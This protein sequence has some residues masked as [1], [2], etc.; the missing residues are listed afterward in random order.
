[1]SKIFSIPL[2]SLVDSND[3]YEIYL[4]FL[5]K[6]K[7]YIYDVY[8]T[9]R[10]PPFLQDAMGMNIM[11]ESFGSLFTNAMEIQNTI[12]IKVSATFNNINVSPSYNNLNIFIENLKPLYKNGLRSM[13]IPHTHW[14]A[15]GLKDNFPEMEIKNTILR[16]VSTAQ[17]YVQCAEQGF[18]YVNVDRILMRDH[19]E[20]KRIKKAQNHIKDKYDK[21][22]KIALLANEG[23]LGRCPIMDEHYSYNNMMTMNDNQY[24]ATEISSVSCTKWEKEDPA[25][26]YKTADIPLFKEDWDELLEYV[27]I[28][29]MHGREN[30]GKLMETMV[31]IKD[32]VKGKK[33]LGE[34]FVKDNSFSFYS[35]FIGIPQK[36]LDFWRDKIK[37]CK[38][39][40]WDCNY[41]NEISSYKDPN[42]KFQD[43]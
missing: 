8:F 23:C 27:D 12:G 21:I 1:M 37:V 39:Q 35:K 3:F 7:E 19:E 33:V 18:D 40:C 17:D 41:C 10:V 6:H 24:F 25:Y 15:M 4:P 34:K 13:T 20:L 30:P 36:R 9:C 11:E 2:N 31:I 38:F 5:D 32:Y 16:K 14:V 26:L 29:K 42:G 28:F 43:Y 22:V